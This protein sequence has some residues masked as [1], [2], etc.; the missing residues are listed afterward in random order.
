MCIRLYSVLHSAAHA[1]PLVNNLVVKSLYWINSNKILDGSTK[2]W[3]TCITGKG[4]SNQ[5]L[6]D[7]LKKSLEKM[8]F[9]MK[10]GTFIA[11]LDTTVLGIYFI[12]KK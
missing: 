1:C 12:Y 4:K 6:F 10:N 8:R 9:V 11:T 7:L 3:F 2:S 5:V